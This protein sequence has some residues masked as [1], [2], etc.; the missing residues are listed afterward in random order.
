MQFQHIVIQN[1][2]E[3]CISRPI[4]G[5]RTQTGTV[6]GAG[7]DCVTGTETLLLV[8]VA[9]SVTVTGTGIDWGI[10]PCIVLL[11]LRL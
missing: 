7:E 10:I 6:T 2:V 4:G 8:L 5:N 11:C 3:R 9:V 1:C